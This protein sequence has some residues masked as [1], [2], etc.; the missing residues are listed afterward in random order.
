MLRC[1]KPRSHVCI[2]ISN[3]SYLEFRNW[4]EIEFPVGEEGHQWQCSPSFS[5]IWPCCAHR[6]EPATGT[7]GSCRKSSPGNGREAVVCVGAHCQAALLLMSC[8]GLGTNYI[9]IS[10]SMLQALFFFLINNLPCLI[11][12]LPVFVLSF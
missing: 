9:V 7:G 3:F 6:A 2:S 11:S 4:L 8:V 5:S 12:V 10:V 1:R